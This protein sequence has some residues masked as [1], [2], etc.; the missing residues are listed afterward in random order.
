MGGT[1][2]KTQHRKT[3]ERNL[4]SPPTAPQRRIQTPK[5]ETFVLPHRIKRI[6]ITRS[7]RRL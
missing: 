4:A 5:L 7:R 1:K 3:L 6:V 2:P